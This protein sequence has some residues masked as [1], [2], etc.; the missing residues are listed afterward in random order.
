LQTG[1]RCR[2]SQGEKLGKRR[3]LGISAIVI[4]IIIILIVLI[5]GALLVILKP[6]FQNGSSSTL[7]GIQR[8]TTPNSSQSAQSITQQSVSEYAGGSGYYEIAFNGSAYQKT[9]YNSTSPGPYCSGGPEENCIASTSGS[10]NWS[11]VFYYIGSD[12]AVENLNQSSMAF[13]G[14]DNYVNPSSTCRSFSDQLGLTSLTFTESP[15]SS[16]P[17]TFIAPLIGSQP[18]F[19]F[20]NFTVT[21]CSI[22]GAGKAFD[23]EPLS[24]TTKLQ[25]FLYAVTA[26][27]RFSF[28][29]IVGIYDVSRGPFVSYTYGANTPDF[30]RTQTWS[31]T[32]TIASIQCSNIPPALLY[33]PCNDTTSS[34]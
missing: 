5:A 27:D 29:L 34:P 25:S 7:T 33:T 12:S 24:N 10:W 22:S 21:G 26:F 31:G 32:V 13:D 4:I 18:G 3:R 15:S 6:S 16:T 1:G 19:T 14:T 8:L 17:Y 2:L 11:G 30:N 23:F 20:Q 28:P 9:R